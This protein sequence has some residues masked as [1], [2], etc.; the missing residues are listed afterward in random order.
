MDA[1]YLVPEIK[2][3][4]QQKLLPTITL[5]NRQEGRPRTDNFD[6]A[7]KAEIRDALWMLTKQWQMG[8]FQG[9]DAGSPVMVKAH[10]TTSALRQYQPGSG[11]FQP[12]DDQLPLE[13]LVEQKPFVMEQQGHIQHMDLRLQL[14]RRWLKLL[15]AADMAAYAPDYRGLYGFTLPP[16]GEHSSDYVYAHAEV[17]RQYAAVAGRAMDGYRLYSYLTDG[18]THHASDGIALPDSADAEILNNLGEEF[19]SWFTQLYQQPR[20]EDP[21][22]WQPPYLEYQFACAVNDEEQHNAQYLSR[23]YFHGTPDWYVFNRDTGKGIP[24]EDPLSEKGAFTFSMLPAPIVFDG[25]PDTRW[26]SFEDRKTNF[27]QV[28]PDTTDLAKLLLLEFSLVYANDWF[29]IPF[30]LPINSA[31]RVAGLTV[32]N[33]FGETTWIDPSGYGQ[34]QNW[35]RWEMFTLADAAQRSGPS[36]LLLPALTVKTQ[37][38]PPQEEIHFIRD[39]MANMVWAVEATVPS[40]TG[41]GKGGKEHA[42]E[43]LTYH[44]KLVS[45]L[46]FVPQDYPYQAAI[47]YLSMTQVPEHW[48]P[49]QPVHIEGSNREIQLQRAKML[50]ILE[51]DTREP[52]RVAPLTTL[53]REG[54]DEDIPLPYFIHE[55]EILRSGIIVTQQFQR[56]RWTS[57]QVYTWY[58]ASKKTGR[59]E[60]SSG[61]AFDQILPQA[62]DRTGDASD[63]GH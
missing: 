36:E 4:L 1:K 10:V 16:P 44:K 56:T 22:A 20:S 7:M 34:G 9:D 61:L 31:A 42:E 54:L 19:T 24:A 17:W 62:N 5:W 43:T 53:L 51:G 14:G 63:G 39:E 55:E 30:R 40:V 48:I 28:K 25:M 52:E 26:W 47:S 23:E 12:M 59:G 50:R 41:Y 32:T 37:E 33:T 46:G 27:A 6:R 8:E 38:G 35:H 2:E 57:G 49:F 15:E 58:G 60:G 18:A 45:L 11:P 3:A 13:T 29:I 21:H